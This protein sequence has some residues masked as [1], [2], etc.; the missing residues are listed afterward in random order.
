MKTAAG[1][2]ALALVLL[3][4]VNAVAKPPRGAVRGRFTISPLVQIVDSKKQLAEYMHWSNVWCVWRGD[5]VIV[6]VSAKNT[7]AEHVTASIKPR[8]YIARGGIHGDGPISYQDKGFDPG[9]FRSLMAGCGTSQRASRLAR[10]YLAAPRTS[11]TSRAA[12]EVQALVV[13]G[14]LRPVRLLLNLIWLVLAG[15][16]LAIEYLIAGVIL[17][18][19]II[20]IPFGVQSFKLTRVYRS[21]RLVGCSFPRG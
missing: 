16:W 20:G 18:I 2:G 12:S 7:A 14:R 5:H 6:H 9:E 11:G 3:W 15:I 8:Y 19:T 10:R 21:G 1:L 17:C 4:A 13:C